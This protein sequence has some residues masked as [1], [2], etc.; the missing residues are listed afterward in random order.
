MNHTPSVIRLTQVV[1]LLL[2]AGTV[3]AATPAKSATH[4][5]PEAVLLR[6]NGEAVRQGSLDLLIKARRQRG[7]QGDLGP[8]MRQ[9]LITRTVLAQEARKRKLDQNEQVRL[10]NQ[11]NEQA[12]LGQAYLREYATSLKIT[13]KMARSAYE[14]YLKERDLKEFRIRQILLR[15]EAM[16]KKMIARLEAGD[17]FAALAKEHSVD[18]GADS[19]GGEIGW[20]RPDL[21]VDKALS[22]AVEQ[23]P[24]GEYT[25]RPVQTRFGWHVVLVEDGPRKVKLPTFDELDAKWKKMMR[26]RAKMELVDA[27]VQRLKDKAKVVATDAGKQAAAR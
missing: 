9:E 15:D 14:K 12:V 27:H 22:T 21:F 26:Q 25:R 20:F 1:L 24:K 13:D 3:Q 8:S 18:P 2:G 5:D 6:V 17:D 16:A 4:A 11:L 19:N 10:E 23:T 7:V